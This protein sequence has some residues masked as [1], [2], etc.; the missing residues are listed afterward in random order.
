MTGFCDIERVSIK[1]LNQGKGGPKVLIHDL[2][3]KAHSRGYDQ[4]VLRTWQSNVASLALYKAFGFLPVP[5]F[6]TH[7]NSE[8]IFLG[9]SLRAADA[10]T[11]S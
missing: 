8:L 9:R 3:K 10:Q 1:P 2:L 7:P 6:K 11:L 5:S 4:A